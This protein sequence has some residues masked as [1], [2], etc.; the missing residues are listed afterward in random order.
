VDELGGRDLADVAT[1]GSILIVGK[2]SDN[3]IQSDMAVFR[4]V[5]MLSPSLYYRPTGQLPFL[6]LSCPEI[7]GVADLNFFWLPTSFA[8]RVY[9]K[10]SYRLS[11]ARAKKVICISNFTRDDVLSNFKVP[12]SKICVIHHGA[13]ALPAPVLNSGEPQKVFW[14]SFGHQSHKNIELCLRALALRTNYPDESLVV[15]GSCEHIDH[16]L[17]PLSRKLGLQERVDFVGRVSAD[18]LSWLYRNA[19][20]LLF[21]SKF[22]G[23]GLPILE[24]MSAGC[25]VI[26]SNIA[27]LVEVAG[28]AALFTDVDNYDGLSGHMTTLRFDAEYIVRAK[29][30]GMLRAQLFTW[31]RTASETLRVFEEVW[32]DQ[33]A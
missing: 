12:R 9:K 16:V 25:P 23:F 3:V 24:A 5:R 30:Q 26:A 7:M 22:E 28:D 29:E 4:A 6:P 32:N 8:K 10:V 1:A 2:S 13:T 20:G 17:K 18:K 31:D 33:N 27:S 14:L 15:V 11:L 19:L 21:V